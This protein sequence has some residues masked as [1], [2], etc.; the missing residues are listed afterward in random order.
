MKP[1]LILITLHCLA[2]NELHTG[3]S[4]ES[5]TC[6]RYMSSSGS[7]STHFRATTFIPMRAMI[8]CVSVSVYCFPFF[9][10]RSAA[11]D[12]FVSPACHAK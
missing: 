2:H 4:A 8:V 5:T 1:Q 9:P 10:Y 3:L 7:T 11:E 6:A 12:R